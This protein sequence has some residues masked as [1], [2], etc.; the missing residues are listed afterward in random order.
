MLKLNLTAQSVVPITIPFCIIKV[1]FIYICHN[2]AKQGIYYGDD[3]LNIICSHQAQVLSEA[4]AIF[5]RHSSRSLYKCQ[6]R[7]R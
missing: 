5:L 1:H 7:H 4:A 2:N 3:S 6:S